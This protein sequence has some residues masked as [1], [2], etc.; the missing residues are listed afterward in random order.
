MTKMTVLFVAGSAL[1]ASV[2]SATPTSPGT[3]LTVS[4]GSLSANGNV[5]AVFL[6]VAAADTSN[7]DFVGGVANPI[8]INKGPGANSPG[9]TVNLGTQSGTIEFTLNNLTA[10]TSY[11]NDLADLDGNYHAFYSTNAITTNAATNDFNVNFSQAAID[12]VAALTGKVTIVGFEDRNSGRAPNYS[13]QPSDWDY[14]DLI[15]AFSATKLI[16]PHVPEP[17]A[18]ALFG[19][20]VGLAGV[21]L[22]YRRTR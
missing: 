4:P 18:I 17:G 16:P 6:Y 9:D 5:K 7:L 11:T 20:G 10:G 22:R 19:L 2:A 1:I 14:N 8:F 3:P 13:G 12:A 21:A 15:Y